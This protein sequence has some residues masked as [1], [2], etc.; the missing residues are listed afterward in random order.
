MPSGRSGS[1]Y[2]PVFLGMGGEVEKGECLVDQ[3]KY[4]VSDVLVA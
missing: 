3:L 4:K 1:I 2:K